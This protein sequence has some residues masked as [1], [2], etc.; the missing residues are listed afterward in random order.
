[1]K[2]QFKITNIKSKIYDCKRIKISEK[3]GRHI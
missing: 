2:Y 1:M 3:V